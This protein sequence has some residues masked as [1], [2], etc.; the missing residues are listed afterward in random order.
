MSAIWGCISTDNRV[1]GALNQKMRQPFLK[2]KIDRYT[3]SVEPDVAMGAGIQHIVKEA[4]EECFPIV[5]EDNLFL[6]ADC[7]LDNYDELKEMLGCPKESL[8]DGKILAA[9]YAKWGIECLKYM[10]GQ[11]AFAVY[12]REQQEVY[13]AVDQMST[14]CLYYAV[15]EG[16]IYFSTLIE[17]IRQA[18]ICPLNEV[19]VGET[20]LMSGLRLQVAGEQTPY[21]NVYQVEAG[22]YLRI[23]A[24]GIAKS[25]YWNPRDFHERKLYANAEECGKSC[26]RRMEE[27]VAD[28]LRASGGVAVALSSGLDSTT[29][30]GIAATQLK[31]QGK[32]LN[33]YT[34]VPLA[35]YKEKETL[36]IADETKG[37]KYFCSMHSNIHPHFMNNPDCDAI[38]DMDKMLDILEM[39]Y[40]AVQNIPVLS[41]LYDKAYEDGCRVV[42]NGH[43]GNV[44]ISYGN[45]ANA[46]YD[47]LCHGHFLKAYKLFMEY[48][49]KNRAYKKKYA[50]YLL[51]EYIKCAWGTLFK[52]D[53]THVEY[54]NPQWEKMKYVK[55]RIN[56]LGHGK[57][58]PKYTTLKKYREY[59]YDIGDLAY[60][61]AVNTKMGLYSGVIV[62]DPCQDIR[63]MEECIDYPNEAFVNNGMERW[64]VRGNM[65]RYVPERLLVNSLYRGKQSADWLYR[66]QRRSHEAIEILKKHCYDE[67]VLQYV[68]EKKVR[69]Y[70]EELDGQFREELFDETNKMLYITT[71]AKFLNKCK[72]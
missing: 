3:E 71:L 33:S 21:T 70:F 56:S 1:T 37:V 44:T 34:Y 15:E 24:E 36:S 19:F 46:I 27:S 51:R 67:H 60:L 45:H 6:T 57:S 69:E 38:S 28:S 7:I 26:V 55:N 18:I 39:P 16:N 53:V 62:R 66:L 72:N 31:R 52:R 9:A 61:G 14:R 49:T 13:L 22:T 11:F 59:L 41:R 65:Q 63:L 58:R 20:L 17:S 42:L 43:Y 2:Y 32:Q 25:S 68:S 35:E 40:K 12:D 30:A 8:C 54:I 5:E 47:Y 4:E 50:F 64:L 10:R 48:C 23:N 29:V